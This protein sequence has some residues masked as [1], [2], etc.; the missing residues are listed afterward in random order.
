MAK[1]LERQ[2]DIFDTFIYENNESQEKKEV[3]GHK[4]HVRRKCT[5]IMENEEI[6]DL[7]H[8]KASENQWESSYT[9]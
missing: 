4:L 6:R 3:K 8:K 2:N 7:I 1:A 9:E 5:K